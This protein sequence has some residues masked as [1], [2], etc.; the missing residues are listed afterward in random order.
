M[1]HFV[2]LLGM[3]LCLNSV[4]FGADENS[5]GDYE[6]GKCYY[7]SSFAVSYA[8]EQVFSSEWNTYFP[9]YTTLGGNCTNFANQAIMAGLVGTTSPATVY[10]NRL[11]YDTDYYGSGPNYWYYISKTLVSSSWKGAGELYYYAINNNNS[12]YRGLHFDFITKDSP[13]E[14]LNFSQIR[15]GDVIFADW[16]GNNDVDH[17]MIVT[18]KSANTYSGTYVTYQSSEGTTPKRNI[19]LSQINDINT[20]FHV[21]RP[22]FYSD[23]GY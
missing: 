8:T 7:D 1:K 21:Y 13:T 20:V 2:L 12:T 11:E 22:T 5:C 4:A 14:A 15:L 6:Y 9:D 17:T 10:N 18:Y 23:T 3:L 19:S 16:D